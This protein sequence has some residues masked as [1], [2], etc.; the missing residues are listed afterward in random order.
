MTTFTYAGRDQRGVRVTG[1]VEANDASQ[2]EDQL[3]K[4]GLFPIEITASP[5]VSY[6]AARLSNLFDAKIKIETLILFCRQMHSLVKA[7]V[8]I[9]SAIQRIA[10]I[11]NQTVLS[12]TL[13]K[14]A[15][16]IALGTSLSSAMQHYP[17]V[18][19][20]LMV[21][22]ITAGEAT[23]RLDEAFQQAAKYYELANTS[24]R[25][26]KTALRYPIFVMIFAL[27]A[28]MVMNIFVIPKFAA[29]YSSFHAP[30]P[31]PTRLLISIA[32]FTRNYWWVV[33]LCLLG[34]MGTIGL[35]LR[36]PVIRQIFDHLQF[37]IPIFGHIIE[38]IVMVNFS[39]SLAVLL[40]TG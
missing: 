9:V 7:G 32:F 22:L 20:P 28:I 5:V 13:K 36:R 37:K 17:H 2:A 25:R 6:S 26:I 30:L 35:L 21:A 40:Q 10:E 31:M 4:Q 11:T 1:K 33:M 39:H 27:S 19:E 15:D 23:G 12:R 29:L 24:R 38:R 8:P 3:I 18:F 14:V 34:F 16:E